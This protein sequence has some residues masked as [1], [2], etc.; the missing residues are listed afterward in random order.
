MI[1][2]LVSSAASEARQQEDGEYQVQFPSAYCGVGIRS[3]LNAGHVVCA[4]ASTRPFAAM[5]SMPS[6]ASVLAIVRAGW[7]ALPM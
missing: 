5:H 2:A 4:V 3:E 7:Q 6:I 1:A